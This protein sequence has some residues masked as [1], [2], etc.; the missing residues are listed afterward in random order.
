MFEVITR[1]DYAL[2][3][4]DCLGVVLVM[5]DALG[6]SLAQYFPAYLKHRAERTPLTRILHG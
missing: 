5:A 4:I 2:L 1:T 6:L 3:V